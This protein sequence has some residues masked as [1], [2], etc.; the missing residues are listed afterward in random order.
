M[1]AP[2]PKALVV[3][4]PAARGGTARARWAKVA[5]RVA[6]QI[7][8]SVV[9]T[10]AENVWTTAVKSAIDNGVRLFIAAGGDGSVNAVLNAILAARGGRPLHTF[11]IGAV[12][13]GSSNDFHK[14]FGRREAGIPLRIDPSGG[15]VRDVVVARFAGAPGETLARHFVVSASIGVAAEANATFNR[16]GGV[17]SWLKSHST[18]LAILYALQ[19]T[20][21]AYR[22][23][24]ATIRIGGDVFDTA[25]TS[26][27]ILKTPYVSG[28][29]R[30]DM[31]VSPQD[32]RVAVAL[33]EG[34]TR[35]QTIRALVDLSRGR[36][37]GKPQRRVWS[38]TAVDIEATA[39][40][41]LELD[42]EVVETRAVSFRVLAEPIGVCV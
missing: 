11:K 10:D 18:P 19:R 37:V 4:N 21:R 17:Q 40:F 23:I 9:E 12:G 26:L 38:A 24:A 15:A 29:F 3:L 30:F 35:A 6:E 34:M 2:R 13:L 20:L 28:S 7:D 25:I 16:S 8:A 1:A 5:A 31:P 22:N 14:P 36:F 27:N 41:A 32:G 39:P 33:C 42:G